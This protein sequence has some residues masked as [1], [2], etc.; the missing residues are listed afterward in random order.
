MSQNS[1]EAPVPK[2]TPMNF[3]KLLRTTFFKKQ[4]WTTASEIQTLQ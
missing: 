1:Q 2:E 3:V 4:L